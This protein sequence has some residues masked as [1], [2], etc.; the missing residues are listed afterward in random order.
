[1]RVLVHPRRRR[2]RG[3]GEA[4][5]E[6]LVVGQRRRRCRRRLRG[7]RRRR[8]LR[9]RRCAARFGADLGRSSCSL[10]GRGGNTWRLVS[11]WGVGH[12]LVGCVGVG[13]PLSRGRGGLGE[14]VVWATN[15]RAGAGCGGLRKVVDIVVVAGRLGGSVTRRSR[16][17]GRRRG[18]ASASS[19]AWHL[20]GKLHVEEA[21]GAEAG[22]NVRSGSPRRRLQLVRRGSAESRRGDVENTPSVVLVFRIT[23]GGTLFVLNPL[24]TSKT[25]QEEG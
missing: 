4:L 16:R 14:G 7:A 5:V 22:R 21:G 13:R 11:R 17:R 25:L 23:W 24:P 9:E 18:L 3:R 20:P 8:R 15:H 2:G 12:V 1:M 6:G 10:I 19:A